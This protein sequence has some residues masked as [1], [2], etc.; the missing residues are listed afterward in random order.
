M[1][2][3]RGLPAAGEVSLT[4]V[5][6]GAT[7]RVAK[8]LQKVWYDKLGLVIT[9]RALDET[10]MAENLKKGEF[11]MALVM[12]SCERNDAS[13][14]LEDW[15]SG[16]E[17]N[18]ANIHNSAYDLLLR[19][20]HVSTSAEARDAYLIDAE[21]MLL[22]SGYVVPVCFVTDSWKLNENLKGVFGDGVGA[23]LFSNVTKVEK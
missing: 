21:Q 12:M 2:R 18:Y 6:D 15:V 9:L 7:D 11:S 14:L 13:Y 8:A 3:G 23:Y 16:A 22:E 20:C 17:S 1:I 10:T 5:S 19:S 4:Y